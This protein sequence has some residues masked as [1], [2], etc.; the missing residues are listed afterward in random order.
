M[1]Y[2]FG[3]GP[4]ISNL[5]SPFLDLCFITEGYDRTCHIIP[6]PDYAKDDIYAKC[7]EWVRHP[8]LK[9]AVKMLKKKQFPQLIKFVDE[10][11]NLEYSLQ[12]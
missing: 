10:E 7:P 3:T 1:F 12:D 11:L 6:L 9:Q 5:Q 8:K 4:Y 2:L